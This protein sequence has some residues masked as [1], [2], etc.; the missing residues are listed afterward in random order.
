MFSLFAK[1]EAYIRV[2]EQEFAFRRNRI[3]NFNSLYV[4]LKKEIQGV[5]DRLLQETGEKAA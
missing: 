4:M 2:F 3:G 5:A 1:A